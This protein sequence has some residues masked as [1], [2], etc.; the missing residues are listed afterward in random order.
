MVFTL[1]QPTN[2]PSTNVRLPIQALH[3][4]L[5]QWRRQFHQYPELG[6]QEQLTAAHIAETLTKLEIPHT[7]GIAKTGIM[8]TVDSG[9]PGPVLAIRADMDAL[10]VTEENEVDYRSLHPGKMHAC[11]HDGHT[12]IALGTAQYLAAHRDSFRGQ[13]KFFFQPAEEGP[14]GA[15]PMIEA[16][17]L[18]NPAVDA[19]VGLHLWND[20]PVGTVG[21]KPGPVMAAVE[22]F[23]CQL[24]GQGGH[25]AMPHQTVDTLVISAQIVM[26][27]Q[28]IVA[29]N[30]NPLQSAVVTV[31]Q[32]QS[33]TAFN[34]IPDSAYFRGTVRYFDP[35][36]AG[37]FA[38]RIEEIIKG[39]CQ[40]HGANYQFTYENIYPPV[41]NDRRLADLVRSAAADVLLTDDHLQPDYQTLAGE[42]MSFFLQAVPGCYFFLGSAN[43]DLGLAYPHHHPRF[44]FDE[45][46]LPVGVELFV[47]CVERFCN[48]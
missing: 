1:P 31:G 17:V 21:I 6:F 22:H 9:K 23:E 30:L 15:K 24:F 8:A 41:V 42:D 10:P 33:G 12:A 38:Q 43:G 18:E 19:I 7:P 26:A 46:V 45:A 44:N 4:Q 16:G 37:Y 35:S 25:G 40:S 39:I 3:G 5:I 48:A 32:L 11:G 36:F 20:L 29:R 13:V 14:G 47:R 28:G 27:L 2:L 34:V